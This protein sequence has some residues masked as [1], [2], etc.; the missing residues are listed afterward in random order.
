M[1]T[2]DYNVNLNVYSLLNVEIKVVFNMYK[3]TV[4][5]YLLFKHNIL[6]CNILL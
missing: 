2:L 5:G 1:N 6:C 3:P 4:G